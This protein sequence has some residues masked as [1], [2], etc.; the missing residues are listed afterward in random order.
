MICQPISVIDHEE[1]I[2]H[3]ALELKMVSQAFFF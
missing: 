2:F 3:L 1:R